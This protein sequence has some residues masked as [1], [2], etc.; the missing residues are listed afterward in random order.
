MFFFAYANCLL[1]RIFPK[2]AYYS[3]QNKKDGENID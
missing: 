2:P 1:F 3:R